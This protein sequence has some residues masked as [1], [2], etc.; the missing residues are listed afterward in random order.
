MTPPLCDRYRCNRGNSTVT[1][2]DWPTRIRNDKL[3]ER[4]FAPR[5]L[6]LPVS[7]L[8]DRRRVLLGA[9]G[10]LAGSAVFSQTEVEPKSRSKRSS[11]P[12]SLGF[13]EIR[14]APT[15]TDRLPAGY[16]RQ[17]LLRW[18]DPLFPDSPPFDPLEQSAA[19][20]EKQFGY[21]N[22]Y[23]AWIPLPFGS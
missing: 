8:I 2:F 15:S 5:G 11:S 12:S 20:A 4:D 9:A 6:S 18:G 23:T 17:V 7:A 21:N 13:Q 10:V 3:S 1:R 19:A 14:L 16:R 22:D